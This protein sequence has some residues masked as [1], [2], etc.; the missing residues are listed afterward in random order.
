MRGIEKTCVGRDVDQDREE[1][2]R[3]SKAQSKKCEQ[4]KPESSVRRKVC[5]CH[6]QGRDKLCGGQRKRGEK[7]K[8]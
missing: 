6:R 7:G 4:R 5:V 1:R 2:R 3:R 8:R